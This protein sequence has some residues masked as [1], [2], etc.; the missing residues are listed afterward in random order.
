MVQ[1]RIYDFPGN[2]RDAFTLAC[3]RHGFVSEDFEVSAEESDQRAGEGIRSVTVARVVGGALQVY[4]A[5]GGGSWIPDFEKDLAR[6]EF[7]F[8][9]AD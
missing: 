2:E 1:K 3:A 8:P 6:N 5:T 4:R 9:L 7:G